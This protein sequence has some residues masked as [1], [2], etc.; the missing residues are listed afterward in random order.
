MKRIISLIVCG[1]LGL[2]ALA[3]SIEDGVRGN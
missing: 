1:V 3:Q 2:T